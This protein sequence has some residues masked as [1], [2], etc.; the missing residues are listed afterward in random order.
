MKKQLVLSVACILAV[1]GLL[2]L[3]SQP[4]SASAHCQ[5]IQYGTYS[6]SYYWTIPDAYG[7]DFFNMRFTMPVNGNLTWAYIYFYQAGSVVNT[8]EG[9]DIIVWDDVGGLPGTELGRVNVP[10]AAITWYPSELAVNLSSLGLSFSAGQDFHI[11]CTTVNQSEDVYAILSDDGS[12]PLGRSSEYYGGS[13]DFMYNDW[14]ID[15]NFLMAAEVCY[16]AILVPGNYP[17]IQQAV[18]NASDGEVIMV[19]DGLYP[20][21]VVVNKSITLMA[22]SSPVIDG[23]GGVGITVTANHTTVQGLTLTNCS[24]GVYV[25]ND[26]FVLHHVWLENITVNDPVINDSISPM[27]I[28]FHGVNLSTILNSL[29]D[30]ITT[31]ANNARGLYLQNC[32]LNHVA[33]LTIGD[34]LS[35]FLAYGLYLDTSCNNTL[36]LDAIG[37]VSGVHLGG[38]GEAYGIKLDGCGGS[39]HNTIACGSLGDLNGSMSAYGIDIRYSDHNNVTLSGGMGTIHSLGST[40]SY[41]VHLQ[42]SHSNNLSTGD[43]GNITGDHAYG[44]KLYESQSNWLSTG[45]FGHVTATRETAAGI[46][47]DTADYNHIVTESFGDISGA[48][49]A[50]GLWLVESEYN[51]I[52]SSFGHITCTGDGPGLDAFGICLFNSYGN[53][54]TNFSCGDI[55]GSYDALG[56]NIYDSSDNLVTTGPMGNITARSRNAYGIYIDY[57]NDNTVDTSTFGLIQGNSHAY[58]IFV[59]YSHQNNVTTGD[60]ENVSGAMA[61][62]VVLSYSHSNNV[63]TGTLGI[64]NGTATACGLGINNSHHNSVVTQSFAGVLSGGSATS[65]GV[66]ITDSS[67]NNVTTGSF[68]D[69]ESWSGAAYGVF[70][71]RVDN[72]TVATQDFGVVSGSGDNDTCGIY[73]ENAEHNHISTGDFG[74]VSAQYCRG[75]SLLEAYHNNI[76]AGGFGGI[77]GALVQGIY[78]DSSSCNS[79]S[80]HAFGDVSSSTLYGIFLSGSGGNNISTGSFGDLT[81]YPVWGLYLAG[82]NGNNLS[83][84][85]FGNISVSTGDATAVYLDGSDRNNLST[86]SFGTIIASNG[87]AY[88]IHATWSDGNNFTLPGFDGINGSAGACGIYLP[89]IWDGNVFHILFICNVSSTGGDAHGVWLSKAVGNTFTGL[90]IDGVWS[91]DD[92]AYGIR[93]S[94][95][96]DGSDRNTFTH[97]SVTGISA[98]TWW[99]FHACQWSSGNVIT[100]LSL[101]SYPVTVDFTYGEGIAIKSVEEGEAPPYPAKKSIDRYVNIANITAASWINITIHYQDQD[102][103]PADEST[104]GIYRNYGVCWFPVPSTLDQD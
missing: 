18:D 73:M 33:N 44:I 29:L 30:N 102:L 11:G 59:N 21:N 13:W 82:S 104:L 69:I 77:I 22:G 72:N 84:G 4:A 10:A 68:G 86:G 90:A 32:H 97:C 23:M 61:W 70:L 12:A 3:A 19:G 101:Y 65:Y 1:V 7:D 74:Q 99:S 78:L 42:Y 93:L 89:S 71:N 38:G 36:H 60:L 95:E 40:S 27:G 20:E 17:T 47:L 64:V 8:S 15:V 85:D 45:S 83:T 37:N 98:P 9:V 35:E 55:N 24:T 39:D 75:I 48:R 96:P 58:G 80:T 56:V 87:R 67:D 46:Y 5:R 52:D 79:I 54:L 31:G 51:T 49:D 6:A 25:H 16:D 57:A 88:G 91:R 66:N 94:S 62:G 53:T 28:H 34:V 92:T 103:G 63:T 26:S 81:G 100:N 14:G 50:Y 41:G 43:F 76:S 2:S